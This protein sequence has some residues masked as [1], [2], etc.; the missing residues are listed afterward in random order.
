MAACCRRQH[1]AG[2]PVRFPVGLSGL[3]LLAILV[4]GLPCGVS[5]DAAGKGKTLADAATSVRSHDDAMEAVDEGLGGGTAG[6]MAGLAR[7]SAKLRA[8]EASVSNQAKLSSKQLLAQLRHEQQT[9]L[10]HDVDS[11]LHWDWHKLGTRSKKWIGDT[12]G[13]AHA[14]EEGS[15]ANSD[16]MAE[17]E[18]NPLAYFPAVDPDDPKAT[19]SPPSSRRGRG[20]GGGGGTDS[21]DSSSSTGSAE[22]GGWTY[23]RTGE[24]GPGEWGK[25]YPLCYSGKRQSPIDIV[26]DGINVKAEDIFNI[27]LLQWVFPHDVREG[28]SPPHSLFMRLPT[29]S[30]F[31]NPHATSNTEDGD[32][33]ISG[34]QDSSNS[35]PTSAPNK[36]SSWLDAADAGDACTNTLK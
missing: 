12:A 11:D 19:A 31:L 4:C 21:V 29:N 10:E 22:V 25:H 16:D 14:Q 34:Q 9:Q 13:Q 17:R 28:E 18:G 3:L 36:D 26:D 15:L 2:R 5:S 33:H 6:L 32:E 27:V 20:R 23:S 1:T 24:N 8:L 30:R 7:T 35:G